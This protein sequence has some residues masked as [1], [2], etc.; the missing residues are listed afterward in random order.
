M[1]P[2]RRI[3]KSAP[4][5]TRGFT[6]G[7]TLV[8]LLVVIGIIAILIGI[9]LPALSRARDAAKTAQCLSNLRQIGNAMQMYVNESKGWIVPAYVDPPSGKGAGAESW[10]TILV[11]HKYLPAPK[12]LTIA[13]LDQ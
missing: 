8:E 10:A 3:M 7:F 11:N 5:F 13:N 4:A 1:R 6:P 2:T 12:Q 9:L